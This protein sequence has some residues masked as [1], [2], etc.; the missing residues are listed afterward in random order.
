LIEALLFVA[1][2]SSVPVQVRAEEVV[3][4]QQEQGQEQALVPVLAQVS[5]LV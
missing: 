1:P 2:L 3:E 5:L 4:V